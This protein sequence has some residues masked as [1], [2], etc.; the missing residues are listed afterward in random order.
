[1]SNP[2]RK[3]ARKHATRA[4][5][6]NALRRDLHFWKQLAG[7]LVVRLGG[8]V[9]VLQD[10]GERPNEQLKVAFAQGQVRLWIERNGEPI[11]K[12][13]GLVDLDGRQL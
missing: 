12:R 11:K 7:C 5:K 1:M 9:T 3:L 10:E 6:N 4:D 2:G 8:E 13:S